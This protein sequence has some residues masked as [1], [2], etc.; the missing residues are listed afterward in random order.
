[1]NKQKLLGLYPNYT[2]VLGPYIRPDGRK[3]VIL[4]NTNAAKGTKGKTKTISYPKALKEIE[5]NKKLN[6]D[7]TVDHHDRDFTN[8]KLDNLKVKSRSE[9][10]SQ[11]AIRVKVE[12]VVCPQCQTS[13]TPNKNQMKSNIDKAGPFCSAKCKGT[14]GSDVQNGKTNKLTRNKVVKIYYRIEK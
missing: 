6:P 7:E 12:D 3:H 5:L 10:S 2:S 8:D 9:H 14:Y 13:F 1:M 11:D 4:N